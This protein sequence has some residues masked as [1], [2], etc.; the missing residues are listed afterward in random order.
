MN[1][2]SSLRAVSHA[3]AIKMRNQ[4]KKEGKP[5]GQYNPEQNKIHTG[6]FHERNDVRY[7]ILTFDGT[8]ISIVEGGVEQWQGE[9]IGS[10]LGC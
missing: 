7:Q 5:R 9:G 2:R 4:G 1:F 10:L 6:M 3:L 8:R